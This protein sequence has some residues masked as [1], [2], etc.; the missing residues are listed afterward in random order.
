MKNFH[1]STEAQVNWNGRIEALKWDPDLAPLFKRHSLIDT[2]AGALFDAIGHD[3]AGSDH[4]KREEAFWVL[5][6]AMPELGDIIYER[7]S[8]QPG[9][10][11]GKKDSQKMLNKGVDIVTRLHSYLVEQKRFQ[12]ESGR[13][14]R[15]L[16]KTVAARWILGE[17]KRRA[18][19][20]PL[21]EDGSRESLSVVNRQPL[22]DDEVIDKISAQEGRT[23]I[24]AW[25]FTNENELEWYY[26]I[27]VD[28]HTY[29]EIAPR[30]GLK[31]D[32]MRKRFSRVRAKAI[33]FRDAL[34]DY[35]CD[36]GMTFMF[37]DDPPWN[38][39]ERWAAINLMEK[40]GWAPRAQDS[41]SDRN[42]QECA[43]A[44]EGNQVLIRPVTRSL[45]S[46]QGHL[47]LVAFR[48]S[49][50]G[51]FDTSDEARSVVRSELPGYCKALAVHS[52]SSGLHR[53]D[54]VVTEKL[55]EG[56]TIH[57]VTDID[58]LE[59][60]PGFTDLTGYVSYSKWAKTH[61]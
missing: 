31:A 53:L 27:Y 13:D 35:A 24:K 9:W 16:V 23:E 5:V 46:S 45:G 54:K 18:L 12:L 44:E 36:T 51:H 33:T 26:S 15:P 41:V 25:G 42:W 56:F 59:D 38:T 40:W 22:M 29:E 19:E 2:D 34:I 1:E 39:S 20:V 17:K 37:S 4:Q 10:R 49:S 21:F 58:K 47:R 32:A 43:M 61:L 48:S 30:V 60:V 11:N 3:L 52:G 57:F 55:A 6:G 50:G 8:R 28:G 7:E 14:P